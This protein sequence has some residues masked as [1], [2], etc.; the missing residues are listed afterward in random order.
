MFPP[1]YQEAARKLGVP[2]PTLS[3]DPILAPKELEAWQEGPLKAAWR[4]AARQHHPDRGGDTKVFQDLSTCYDMLRDLEIKVEPDPP[5]P[6]PA[7]D[8]THK[9]MREFLKR[10]RARLA[11]ERADLARQQAEA[12]RRLEAQVRKE[13]ARLRAELEVHEARLRAAQREIAAAKRQV[14]AEAKRLAAERVHGAVQDLHLSIQAQR[15]ALGLSTPP[16][17]RP[18]R[19]PKPEGLS[20]AGDLVSSVLDLGSALG[21]DRLL[22]VEPQVRK[23]RKALRR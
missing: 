23:A 7:E 6:P 10:E 16:V 11:R 17:P 3:Q 19:P 5:P 14:E 2:L 12:Q 18:P 4:T 1:A 20:A 15:E 22:G 8:T 13:E 21:I 9:F